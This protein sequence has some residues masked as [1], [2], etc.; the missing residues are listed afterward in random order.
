MHVIHRDI[1]PSNLLPEPAAS[2]GV[3]SLKLGFRVTARYLAVVTT[4]I[5]ISGLGD[6]SGTRNAEHKPPRPKPKCLNL[7]SLDT[8]CRRFPFM[9]SSE[10]DNRRFSSGPTL[11]QNRVLGYFVLRI[12]GAALRNSPASTILL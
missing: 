10:L 6:F 1:K 5:N 3:Q 9:A 11:A 4:P 8:V 12:F 7:V 2:G